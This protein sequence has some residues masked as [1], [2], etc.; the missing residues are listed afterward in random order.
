MSE[1]QTENKA[2]SA[3]V[4]IDTNDNRYVMKFATVTC[5]VCALAVAISAVALRPFQNQNALNEKR[6]NVLVAS[7]LA[8]SGVKLNNAQIDERFKNVKPV[9]IN[10]ETGQINSEIDASKYD[11]YATAKSA[12]G[13]VL[14]EDPAGIKRMAKDGLVYLVFDGDALKNV[15]LPVQG[16]GL[17]STMYGFLA[18]DLNKENAEVVGLT[19]YQ[20]AE[21]PGL[22]GEIVNPKW[23]AKWVGVVP[24]DEAGHPHIH[25]RKSG[26]RP[27]H[28][29]E[30]DSLSGASLTSRGVENMVNFWLGDS[31][32]K[33]FLTELKAGNIDLASIKAR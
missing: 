25:L 20:H 16:Y 28:K 5:L 7:G 9:A 3:P 29:N 21:T 6:L 23:Q 12:S 33:R 14:K 4:K 22:G 15:V 24:F 32:Y 8:E 1:Q 27:D 19:F 18:L 13:V 31:A 2:L 17:W 11:M 26:A 10:F 30:V